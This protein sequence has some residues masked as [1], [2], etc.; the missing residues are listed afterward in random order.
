MRR[1][2]RE[3]DALLAEAKGFVDRALARWPL[4]PALANAAGKL[5]VRITVNKSKI[6][7]NI[8]S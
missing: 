2:T 4:D 3:R 6:M 7:W 5:E 8:Q 1:G